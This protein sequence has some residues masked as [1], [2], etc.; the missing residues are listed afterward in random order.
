M[1]CSYGTTGQVWPGIGRGLVDAAMEWARGEDFKEMTLP[2]AHEQGTGWFVA[3][4]RATP[5]PALREEFPR[6]DP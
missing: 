2:R 1:N 4:G 5:A 6:T 3:L